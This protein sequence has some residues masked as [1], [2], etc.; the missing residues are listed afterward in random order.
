MGGQQQGWAKRR[1]NNTFLP[2]GFI[3]LFKKFLTQ[4]CQA[5]NFRK[6]KFNNWMVQQQE[7]LRLL[8]PGGRNDGTPG[9]LYLYSLWICSCREFLGFSCCSLAPAESQGDQSSPRLWCRALSPFLGKGSVAGGFSWFLPSMAQCAA[10]MGACTL[11]YLRWEY[12]STS[13]LWRLF[14]HLNENHQKWMQLRG[15][16]FIF[17]FF[18]FWSYKGVL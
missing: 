4:V 6:K 3:S 8:P 10:G 2:I 13:Y 15:F 12:F 18:L 17:F 5:S 7:Q 14:W 9:L 16:G 11:S 1:Y